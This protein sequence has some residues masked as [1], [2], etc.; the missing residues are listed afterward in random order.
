MNII[1]GK[2][3]FIAKELAK[4]ETYLFT[5]RNALDKDSLYLDL[6]QVEKFDFSVVTEN[7]K[8]IFL[9]A[10]SSPDECNNNYDYAYEIN[11]LA[12]GY[13]IGRALVNGA[14]VLFFSSDVIYGDTIKKV[15]EDSVT[16]PF[17]SYAK[18]KDEIEK[19]F[20]GN[21]NFKV[22]RFSYVLAA[23]DKYLSYL[24]NCVDKSEI[25]EVF[26]PFTRK[27]VYI[28]DV[29]VAI[30]E[31]LLNWDEFGNQKF[32]IC[33][34]EFTS[35]KDIADFYNQA[36]GS[37]LKYNL[38][39]PGLNFWDARPKDINIISTY[40]EKLIGRKPTNIKNAIKTIVQREL[41][42]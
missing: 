21:T 3:G 19:K 39:E 37:R 8:I 40:F 13:F 11:V 10:I 9:A 17:G 31:I 18:M 34:E 26:H 41:R 1:I 35:R 7:T 14:K 42:K 29:L 2:D 33:G 12:T 5:S 32:N 27:V 15:S 25:A 24:R 20:E 30:E 28:E 4:R 22:F 23:G 6:E 36:M 16:N 38:S